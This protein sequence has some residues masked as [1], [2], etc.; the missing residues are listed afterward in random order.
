MVVSRIASSLLL[1]SALLAC[2]VHGID[3]DASSSTI[4]ASN[5]PGVL[6]VVH[7]RI[8][9]LAVT[10]SRLYWTT[11]SIDTAIAQWSL[12]SCEKQNCAETVVTYDTYKGQLADNPFTIIGDEVYWY[13]L[14]TAQVL[15]C[16][17]TGCL[18]SPRQVANNIYYQTSAAFDGDDLYFLQSLS[19]YRVPLQRGGARQ[20]VAQMPG[21]QTLGQKLAIHDAYAYCLT[22]NDSGDETFLLRTR[23]D[24]SALEPET[25][26]ND[27]R[28]SSH[29]VFDT[30]TDST[31]VYWTNNLLAG[32]VQRCP[33]TGCSGPSEVVLEPVRTPQALLLD[34]SELYY[35][36]ET[37]PYE[38]AVSSCTLPACVPTQPLFEHL[39]DPNAFAVDDRYLYVAT[40]EQ[41]VGPSG[42][43]P[44]TAQIRRL[45]R[46]DRSSP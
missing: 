29:H 39:T 4:T 16:R 13:A 18:G 19:L 5:E 7:D 17:V 43:G 37:Q 41:E 26:A 12:Y 20:L 34:G 8:R 46:P 42:T 28:H 1:S 33:L 24:G 14:G 10:D 23:K 2:S 30:A 9:K 45:P 15:A 44:I 11:V 25:I 32:S 3:L 40:T 21:I 6:G 27:V 22:Q 36:H 31:S 38:Y 35:T